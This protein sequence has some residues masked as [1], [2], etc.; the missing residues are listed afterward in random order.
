MRR[1]TA[2]I[3]SCL[4]PGR[5]VHPLYSGAVVDVIARAR[6]AIGIFGTTQRELLPRAAS[7]VAR[8][9]RHLV[10][11]LARR[12]DAVWPWPHQCHLSRRLADRAVSARP[13]AR[14]RLLTISED[15]LRDLPLDRAITRSGDIA[16]SSPGSV[17]PLLCAL[18]TADTVAYADDR[19]VPPANSAVCCTIFSAAA[20][21][22][23]SSSRSTARP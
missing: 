14:P 20:F 1:A 5:T 11:A 13:R 12:R 21:R 8:P 6:A 7:I 4:A 19:D 17:A 18:N 22:K 3:S 16:P 10:R 2:T 15:S 9:A 23:T